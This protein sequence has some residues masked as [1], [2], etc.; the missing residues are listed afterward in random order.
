M[1]LKDAW[2]NL[3]PQPD[4][5]IAD[6]EKNSYV[7]DASSGNKMIL[8]E[9]RAYSESTQIAD[10]LKRRNSVVVNC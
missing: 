7:E 5:N 1:A 8:V 9:P 3:F 10:H 4:P 6:T 2:N